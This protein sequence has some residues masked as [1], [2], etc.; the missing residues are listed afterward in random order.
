MTTTVPTSTSGLSLEDWGLGFRGS[1]FPI[2][3]LI[4]IGLGNGRLIEIGLGN[5]PWA[6]SPKP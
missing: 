5:G 6:L 4:E 1:T 3:G 2:T